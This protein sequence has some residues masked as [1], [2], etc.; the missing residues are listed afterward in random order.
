M[1]R[2]R[3]L[4]TDGEQRSTLAATRSLGSAGHQVFVASTRPRSLAAASRHANGEFGVPDPLLEPEP[5]AREIR[6]LARELEIDILIPMTE[7]SALAILC[8]VSQ[9][10]DLLVP[11]PD[12]QTFRAISDKARVAAVAADLGI[13]VPEQR[14]VESRFE[15]MEDAAEFTFPSVL[16]PT[17]SIG[18]AGG[19]RRKLTVQY[20]QDADSFRR[21]MRELPEAAFPLLMQQRIVGPG[22]GIFL[23]LWD[24]ERLATFA[25]RRLR[26]KPPSGGVSVYGESTVADPGLVEQSHALLRRFGWQGVAMVEYKLDARTGTPYL[27][28]VNGRF[29]GSL[30]LAIDAGVDFPTLLLRAASGE[31]F[32]PVET[33]RTG[34]RL[35]WWWGDVDH[36]IARIR[37]SRAALALPPD[38]P[39][40]KSVILEF[41]KVWRRG[42]RNE[43]FRW[44]DP[45][46]FLRETSHWLLRR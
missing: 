3:V 5:F 8:R 17:R 33:Y 1:I 28:E 18:E 38:A 21:A 11:M 7:P 30:Q 23:L 24:G 37:H 14:L 42:E 6:T 16:K 20:V 10:T 15:G 35:R 36:L 25:H 44:S 12:A 9:M 26:E 27:M 45:S 32:P 29:W 41:L 46:P 19:E 40:T 31:R 34:C 22:T 13:R 2:L 39:S 4:L 43:V